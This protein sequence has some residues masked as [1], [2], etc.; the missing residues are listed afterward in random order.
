M[1]DWVL[2]KLREVALTGFHF[3]DVLLKFGH[4]LFTVALR[5]RD[6]FAFV[7]GGALAF[8]D[9]LQARPLRFGFRS[10]GGLEIVKL[11][12]GHERLLRGSRAR[13]LSR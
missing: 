7:G 2:Q 3:G 8:L 11:F 4:A 13:V 5:L 1:H 9:F 10:G 12:A 6:G